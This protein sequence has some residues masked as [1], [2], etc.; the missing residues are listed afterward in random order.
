[1]GKE[2]EVTEHALLTSQIELEDMRE[3]NDDCEAENKKLLRNMQ[4]ERK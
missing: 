1:M 4:K 3:F 2:K